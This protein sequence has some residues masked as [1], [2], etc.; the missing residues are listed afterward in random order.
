MSGEVQN[1]GIGQKV[2]PPKVFLSYSHDSPTHRQQVAAL[3]TSLA[4]DGCDCRLD[5][6]KNTD[7]DWPTWMTRQ[8]LDADFVLCICTRTYNERFRGEGPPEV[9][10][11]AGW[12]GGLV[13]RLLYART[14]LNNRIVPVIFHPT[15]SAFIPLELQ[16]YDYFVLESD[17][18]YLSL[19][20]KLHG[21]R[22]FSRP[23]IGTA[24]ELPTHDIQPLFARPAS[25]TTVPAD[26]RLQVPP[27]ASVEITG[28][29]T[30]QNV[31]IGGA[32]VIQGDA[33]FHSAQDSA[34]PPTAGRTALRLR[35][36]VE[37]L[38]VLAS[39]LPASQADPRGELRK[40]SDNLLQEFGKESQKKER[41]AEHAERLRVIAS[42][43][44]DTGI[45]DSA[46]RISALV[47]TM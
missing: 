17:D 13:R 4:R 47:Q 32:Q 16:G 34:E 42:R 11:G 6:H 20:R 35:S 37:R 10:R 27:A 9:G 24:P 23:V 14:L 28:H 46:A 15:E 36:A 41:L 8:V 43:T 21:A 38:L 39:E 1:V 18:G 29:V 30:G 31:V 25:F 40:A 26:P 12:E 5:L 44:G 7:E 33:L 3:G 22:E 45:Q 2:G 19:L